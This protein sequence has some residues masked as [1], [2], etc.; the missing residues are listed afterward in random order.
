MLDIVL[1]AVLIPINVGILAC[2]TYFLIFIIWSISRS[3][4]LEWSA[5]F[6]IDTKPKVSIIVPARNEESTI[7]KCLQSLLSQ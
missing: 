5:R 7:L 2:W 6:R 1:L 4:K 3:P